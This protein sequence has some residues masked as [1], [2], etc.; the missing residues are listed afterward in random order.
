ME[1]RK[2]W[3]GYI[4]GFRGAKELRVRLMGLETV[5]DIVSGLQQMD[6]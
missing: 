3:G 5:D 1:M 6:S 4:Q 2:C